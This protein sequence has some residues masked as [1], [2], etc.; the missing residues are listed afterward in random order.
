MANDLSLSVKR[1]LLALIA[2][3]RE[4]ASDS[5]LL[6]DWLGNIGYTK[7]TTSDPALA[8]AA[9]KVDAIG[10]AL[11]A[12]SDTSLDSWD[13][14]S[15]LLE[16]GRQLQGVV[17]DLR[18]FAASANPAQA[19]T[20]LPDDVVALLLATWLRRAHPAL[21]RVGATLGVIDSRE[22]GATDPA[23]VVNGATARYARALDRFRFDAI[24]ALLAGPGK[25]IAQAYLPN[26]LATGSDVRLVEQTL[27][28]KLSWLA[29]QLGLAWRIEHP[30]ATSTPQPP[31]IDDITGV[32][33][34]LVPDDTVEQ[35]DAGDGTVPMPTPDPAPPPTYFAQ[36]F[37][38]FTI[39][40]A[41]TATSE[42][43]LELRASSAQHAGGLA[44][45]LLT[46]LGTFQH[47][48]TN[49]QWSVTISSTGSAPSIAIT[50]QGV[51]LA[52]GAQ[53][54]S[55]GEARVK[56]V[57]QPATP[58]SNA[59]AV[60]GNPTG[61][62]LELGA[63][64]AE[65]ALLFD[66]ARQAV[67][68]S[69][70]IGASAVVIAPSDGD[71]FLAEI[72]PAGGLRVPFDLGLDWASDAGLRLRGG[73]GLDATVP[74]A[75]S[76]GPVT[77]SA[78]HLA[79]KAQIDG[80][81]NAEISA[82]ASAA[83]GPVQAS[84]ERVGLTS[85]LSFPATGGNLGVADLSLGLK[86]PTGVG[87]ALDAH[88][89]LTGGGF[90]L[91]DAATGTYA[92]V[93]QLALHDEITLTAVGL[94]ATRLPD[95]RAGYS[96]LV[97]ITAD[98][99]QPIPLGFGFVLQSIGGLVGIHRT[100]D[101]AA[102]T[103]GLK[104]DTLRTLLF[105]RDPV[106]NAPALLHALGAAFPVQRGSYLLGL[107]ARLTWFTPTLVT[108][109]V[110]LV[111]ELGLRTRLLVLG[112][113]SALLPSADN[114]LIRLN[115]DAIGVLDFDAGT[116]SADAVLVDSRLV[117]QFPITGS[118]ALRAR[119]SGDPSMVLAVGG[120][121]PHFAA[122]A[123][124]PTLERVAIALCS[125]SNPRLVCDSY[126]AITANTVQFGA[127]ASLY[128]AA[129][130]FS[131]TG[132]L[133][134]DALVTLVPPHFIIDFRASMQLKRG[135]HNLFG[136]SL[137][138]TLEGPLPLRLAAK[139]KIEI[140]FF[141]CTVHFDYTLADGPASAV[142]PPAVTLLTELTKALAAP[143]SWTTRRASD[144]AQGVALR[145]LPAGTAS[146][147]VLDPLGQLV[148]QQQVVPLNTTRDITTFGGAPVDGPTRFQ[149]VASLNGQPGTA[150]SGE[151]APARYFPLTDDEKLTAPSFETMDAGMIVGDETTRYDA[152]AIV[153]A[154]LTYFPV[155]LAPAGNAGSLTAPIIS[156]PN[157]GGPL[158]STFAGTQ[159][160]LQPRALTFAPPMPA[161]AAPVYV[162]PSAAF[163]R[164]RPSGAAARAPV[165][166]VGR[167][168]F[169]DAAAT[170]AVTVGA[171]GWRIVRV[172]DGDVAPVASGVTTWSEYRD[173]L[174]EL[175]RGGAEWVMVPDYESV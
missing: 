151:F 76:I 115:L 158:L 24:S 5:R 113:I 137:A 164:Q 49:G 70:G 125:G 132:D 143:A 43:A 111:L 65:A 89:V 119:W 44:G 42:I 95:G 142:L 72:L 48:E 105:P 61:T 60:A 101:Q 78:L 8:A 159:T 23:I 141:S 46:P 174:A 38:A 148:V 7:A 1:A 19:A 58:G 20:N 136:I 29:D 129:A 41:R 71:G 145:A 149:V 34:A 53:A 98:G 17:S 82:S 144:T 54:V 26:G 166:R 117:H 69:V 83:I 138:G 139:V 91:H 109:D 67:T 171:P 160:K 169:R 74:V 100:F 173:T 62:R 165:R 30:S 75:L 112:R 47:S 32:D 59:P 168:R 102:L 152:G 13:G 116:L 103:A 124:F 35:I 52:P 64:S 22:S 140:L 110:A 33:P 10:S 114:D 155:T 57:R 51:A 133:G 15:T 40:L 120:L 73:A 4:S 16:T 84:I 154:P 163:A 28:A 156:P 50:P 107:L 31:L 86:P 45:Y 106:G 134:F 77:L 122:P 12:L 128:A 146:T 92:G 68:V 99:F 55:G 36:T 80:T 81:L 14:L 37:P 87:V 27:F 9:T 135:S 2:P 127:R 167:A 18:Q 3:L 85:T 170:P 123:G 25:A 11:E 94:L 56:L 153:P 93:L 21:F 96:L 175:N 90:L 162:L 121:N 150:V 63:A 131:V 126:F 88:G 130:G 97:F 66:T 172:S 39:S 79:L 157:A 6:G 104:S 118:A 147:T 108:I 161:T